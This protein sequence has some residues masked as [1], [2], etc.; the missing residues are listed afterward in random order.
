[1][2][3]L[4]LNR[5]FWPDECA[6]ALLATDL[7]ED[8]IAA[9]HEVHV[10]C[11]RLRYDQAGARLPARETHRGIQIHR[12]WSTNFGRVSTLGRLSDLFTL[13]VSLRVFGPWVCKPDAILAMTDPPMLLN[14][15]LWIRRLRGGKLFH[16]VCDLYPEIAEAL[17]ALR[18]GSLAA[19]WFTWRSRRA[20]AHCDKVFALGEI[21]AERLVQRGVPKN[22]ILVTPPWADGRRLKPLSHEQNAWRRE[23]GISAETVV[24]MYSGNMGRGHEFEVILHGAAQMR[25]NARIMFLFVGSGAQR[26][27]IV[28]YA[29]EHGLANVRLLPFQPLDRLN[30]SLNAGDIHLVSQDPRTIGLIVPSKFGSALAVGRPV[31]FVGD[32]RAEIAQRIRRYDCGFVLN[33]TDKAGFNEKLSALA[34]DPSLREAM[35]SRARS[36]FEAEYAR[37]LVI[38]R[39]R[40][41]L[42][43]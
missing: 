17:G 10:L 39:I 5:F 37:E 33:T 35:G 29:Q 24:V 1:M 23:H 3:I 43:G 8:L 11:S 15:A 31:M 19:R 34:V 12:L 40:S 25:S 32:E 7:A 28:R 26:D 38:A 16:H 30:E 2:R 42:T 6:T 21:M 36:A 18:P 20:L 22:S 14:S 41:A 9:G 4:I 27:V 13:Q